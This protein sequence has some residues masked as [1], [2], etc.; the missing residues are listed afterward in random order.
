MS[1]HSEQVAARSGAGSPR[2]ADGPSTAA[3]WAGVLAVCLGVMMAFLNITGTV[4]ALSAIQTD[5]H[6]SASRLVWISSAYSLLV[7]SVVMSAGTLGDLFG[8]RRIFLAGALVFAAGSALAAAA[9]NTGLLITAEAVMGVGGAAV[10]PTSLSIVSHTFTDPHERTSAISVWAGFSGI[11]LAVGPVL[12]GVLL[13]HFSWHAVFVSNIVL[14]VIVLILVPLLAPESRHPSR[15]FDPA[16][17]VFGTLCLA[18]GTYAI[19][20]GAAVGYA[21]GQILAA[22]VVAVVS[23]VLFVRAELRHR[24]PMI[25]LRLLRN[26]SFSTVMAVS[27]VTLF[28]FV[29][30]ALLSVLYLEEV[31]AASALATGLRLLVMFGTYVVVTAIAARLVRRVGFRVMLTAGLLIM[32]SGTLLLLAIGPFTGFGRMWPGLLLAGLGSGMLIAPA[33][34]AAVN[35]VGP[36]QAG[37]ASGAVNMFRQ[38]GSVLGPSVLGTLV[39]TRFP[40]NLDQRLIA[41]GVPAQVT[42]RAVAAA[43]NGENPSGLPA[44]LRETVLGSAA[45]AFTDATHLGLLIGGLVLIAMAIPTALFVRHGSA[46]AGG[47]GHG[48]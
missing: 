19:I 44:A 10:L 4:S 29:G 27:T 3:R 34:A 31:G 25:E 36:L 6:A 15:Q 2:V 23:L 47:G 16:G 21:S 8:R 7:V 46:Q 17:V 24:D 28:G 32:G 41:Q 30:T 9:P 26:R 42:D 45:R 40:R 22:Y 1:L 20:E 38:L 37:M 48:A 43:A 12:A 33:T 11:G 5:L 39:T 18:A 14:G 13:N 35:S